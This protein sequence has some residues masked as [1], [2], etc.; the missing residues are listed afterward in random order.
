MK[1][2]DNYKD[3]GIEWIGEIPEHW[4][5]KKIKHTTYV[6]GRIG[7]KGLRSDEFLELSDSYVVTGTDF[8]NG[9]IKWKTCY[10]VPIDNMFSILFFRFQ[11]RKNKMENMLSSSY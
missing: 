3:S 1:K 2:Y 7:W 6:K 8:E 11:N 9:K 5:L 4:I 10:Q